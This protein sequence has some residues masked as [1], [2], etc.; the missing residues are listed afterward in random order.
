MTAELPQS[1]AHPVYDP[2]RLAGWSGGRWSEPPATDIRGISID[3]RTL[4]PGNLFVA[5]GGEHADGHR[6]VPRAFELGAAAAVVTRCDPAWGSRVGPRLEVDDTLAALQ[7]MAEGHRGELRA[8]VIGVTGSVGKTTVKELTADI[9]A[10]SAPTARTLGNYNNHIGLPLSL[11]RTAGSARFGVYE[12]GMNHPGELAPLCRLLC[13]RW[14]VLTP[15]GPVHLEFFPSVREIAEEKATLLRAL[16]AD[17][18]AVVSRDE[19]W[20][21]LVTAGL[22]CPVITTSRLGTADY[23]LQAESLQAFTVKEC[24]TG[25]TCDIDLSLPGRFMTDNALLALALARCLGMDWDSIRSAIRA[26]APPPMR[27]QREDRGG[28]LYIN[29]AYNANPVSVR[30]ALDTFSRLPVTGRRWLVLAGM[31]ELGAAAEDEHRRLGVDLASGPWAG[32]IA[33]GGLG[34]QIAAGARE[35]GWDRERI[36]QAGGSRQA[37]EELRRRV[38]EGDAVLLKASR[39]ER[40]EDVLS[41][42]R[43]TGDSVA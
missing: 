37:A 11:L 15:I 34:A 17:G 43:R 23:S 24:R 10:R 36:V 28:V 38:R 1:V 20:F 32:L 29:D 25:E 3:T 41:N 16:P 8:Q 27:W 26:Y 19:P 2:V 33:V 42:L 21:N 9:L 6:F 13:P 7:R 14:G 30:A 12:I 5:L 40:L 18:A 35:A 4:Q 39:G 22:R 31:R